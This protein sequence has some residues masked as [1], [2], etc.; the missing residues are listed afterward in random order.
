MARTEKP[1]GL[2]RPLTEIALGSP[3]VCVRDPRLSAPASRRVG[4]WCCSVTFSIAVIMPHCN[5]ARWSEIKF[6]RIGREGGA[7]R[8][9]PL[10]RPRRSRHHPA[11]PIHGLSIGRWPKL[12]ASR[13]P[14][15][16]VL[17]PVPR[18]GA[19]QP[20]GA[21][22]CPSRR[23]VADTG[24]T[25]PSGGGRARIVGSGP[26][27]IRRR[28]RPAVETC[29]RLA[30]TLDRLAPPRARRPVAVAVLQVPPAGF[31]V[32][33]VVATVRPGE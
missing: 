19:R 32:L 2:A 27:L 7:C 21:A 33:A 10:S 6:F 22:V 28:R 8:P 9:G 29:P 4:F 23:A 14:L 5:R 12:G 1:N 16:R 24:R 17:W 20:L 18:S 30:P 26:A 13:R 25:A 3:A 31:A 15:P 11:V